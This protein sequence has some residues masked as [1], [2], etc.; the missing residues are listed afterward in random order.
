MPI[1]SGAGHWPKEHLVAAAIDRAAKPSGPSYVQSYMPQYTAPNKI[2]PQ[3][4]SYTVQG[5]S[6]PHSPSPSLYPKYPNQPNSPSNGQ[7]Y[8][9]YDTPPPRYSSA[10]PRDGGPDGPGSPRWGKNPNQQPKP[11]RF[12]RA[13]EKYGQGGH[14]RFGN[15]G[16]STRTDFGHNRYGV[17]Y[18]STRQVIHPK[19]TRPV[20]PKGLESYEV[21]G[22]R[23]S[24]I[25]SLYHFH[26]I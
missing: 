7:P 17:Q 14:H 25:N 22:P 11:P 13:S 9:Q 8:P 21:Y 10:N 18:N 6:Q 19:G 2:L 12:G 24:T 15:R 20:G 16:P 1:A 26:K 23:V 3:K 5:P 4:A